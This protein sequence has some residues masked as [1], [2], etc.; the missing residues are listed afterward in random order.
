MLHE[1][2]RIPDLGPRH[3]A[4]LWLGARGVHNPLILRHA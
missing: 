3:E 1:I 2:A 4:E